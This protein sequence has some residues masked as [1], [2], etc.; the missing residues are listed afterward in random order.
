MNTLPQTRI[1]LYVDGACHGNPGPGG[2][3]IV[4]L[5]LNEAGTIIDHQESHGAIDSITTNNRAELAAALNGLAFVTEKIGLDAWPACQ[6]TVISDS[7]YVVKGFTEWLPGWE[8]RGWQT[9]G[10]KAPENR[11]LWERLKAAGAGLSVEW[12]WVSGHSGNRWNKRA[13]ALATLAAVEAAK[14][15]VTFMEPTE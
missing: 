10:G 8:A 3:G 14:L 7:Q 9:K 5:L 13:D 15:G 4:A 1:E 6:V 2:W 12:R 11:R